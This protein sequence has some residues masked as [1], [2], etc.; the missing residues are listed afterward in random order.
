M[1]H[2]TQIFFGSL[3]VQTGSYVFFTIPGISRVP[4]LM[5]V[6]SPLPLKRCESAQLEFV[7]TL[8]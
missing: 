6:S 8:P 1:A 3:Q 5:L 2:A 4:V 7:V